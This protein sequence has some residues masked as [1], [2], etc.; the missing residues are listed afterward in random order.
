MVVSNRGPAFVHA[1]AIDLLTKKGG[2][3][4]TCVVTEQNFSHRVSRPLFAC[5]FFNYGRIEV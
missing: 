5:P 3:P 2:V 1:S 4:K